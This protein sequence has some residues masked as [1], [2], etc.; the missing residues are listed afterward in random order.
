M[1]QRL[2]LRTV[3]ASVSPG[4]VSRRRRAS[5]RA[6]PMFDETFDEEGSKLREPEWGVNRPASK[7]AV[8]PRD[9]FQHARQLSPA[10]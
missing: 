1:A 5:S 7:Q 8:P 4:K 3:D 10:L 2:H 9:R 6:M